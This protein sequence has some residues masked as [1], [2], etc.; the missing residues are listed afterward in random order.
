MP[1]I[2]ELSKPTKIKA[3]PRPFCQFFG[4][5]ES[6]DNDEARVCEHGPARLQGVRLSNSVL[7]S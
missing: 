4:L 5:A 7:N 1:A 2:K 6:S 3:K